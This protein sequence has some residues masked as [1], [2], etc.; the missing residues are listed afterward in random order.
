MLR[1]ANRCS[2]YTCTCAHATRIWLQV[3]TPLYMSPEVLRGSGYDWKSDIWSLGCILYEL[4]QLRRQ[5]TFDA[6]KQV[7]RLLFRHA[8]ASL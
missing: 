1:D 5:G 3:G 2:V 8:V 4:A 7:S 6:S